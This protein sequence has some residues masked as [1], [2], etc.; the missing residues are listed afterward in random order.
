MPKKGNDENILQILESSMKIVEKCDID[1]KKDAKLGILI[2]WCLKKVV[3]Q[4]GLRV[5]MEPFVQRAMC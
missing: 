3:V 4:E 5:E 1:F 2:E